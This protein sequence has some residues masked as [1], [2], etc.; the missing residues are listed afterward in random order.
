MCV[1]IPNDLCLANSPPRARRRGSSRSNDWSS[2]TLLERHLPV[3]L[4]QPLLPRPATHSLVRLCHFTRFPSPSRSP[5]AP[6]AQRRFAPIKAISTRVGPHPTSPYR[7]GMNGH[8]VRQRVTLPRAVAVS[9][10]E[11]LEA[12]VLQIN[13]AFIF[14]DL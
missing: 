9:P 6:A 3:L 13:H 4:S 2:D 5:S 14:K 12:F 10:A 11:V 7:N 8:L 1:D